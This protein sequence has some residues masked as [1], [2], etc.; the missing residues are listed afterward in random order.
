MV[1]CCDQFDRGSRQVKGEPIDQPTED[2]DV[3][4]FQRIGMHAAPCCFHLHA[5]DFIGKDQFK[6]VYIPKQLTLPGDTETLQLGCV[7]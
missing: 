7:I 5:L 1:L 3:L 2:Y 6:K 4:L